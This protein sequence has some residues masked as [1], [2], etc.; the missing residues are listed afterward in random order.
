[1][2]GGRGSS[3]VNRGLADHDV[4]GAGDGD[5]VAGR[6][7]ESVERAPKALGGQQLGD[8]HALDGAIVAGQSH[9]G[10]LL[11]GAVVDAAEWND[12]KGRHPGW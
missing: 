12:R 5:D 6:S 11:E 8:V 3:K 2:M 7:P 1:M 4:F 9:V 10:P